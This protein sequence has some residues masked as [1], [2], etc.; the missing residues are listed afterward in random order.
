MAESGIE[1]SAENLVAPQYFANASEG[2]ERVRYEE[3]DS[4]PLC[5]F[6]DH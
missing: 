5:E 1:Y 4:K 2:S 6:Q 3:V